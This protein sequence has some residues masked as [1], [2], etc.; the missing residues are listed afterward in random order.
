MKMLPAAK[1]ARRWP[2]ISRPAPKKRDGGFPC[3]LCREQRCGVVDSRP[4]LRDGTVKR[5]RHCAAC[6]FRFTT[7]ELWRPDQAPIDFQ[8]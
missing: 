1:S 2:F 7:Y 3:P 8:I 5:V 6:D 4:V